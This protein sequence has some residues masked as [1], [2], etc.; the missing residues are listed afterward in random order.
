M[1]AAS[2]YVPNGNQLCFLSLCEALQDQQMNLTQAPFKLLPLYWNSEHVKL[3]MSPLRVE[4]LFPIA[5]WLSHYTS[6]ADLQSQMFW[7][8][9]FLGV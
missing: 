8:L 1:F 4:S 7:A 2:I 6:P 3:C 5:L 9:I